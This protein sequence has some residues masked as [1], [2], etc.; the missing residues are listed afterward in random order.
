MDKCDYLTPDVH[1]MQQLDPVTAAALLARWIVPEPSLI[2]AVPAQRQLFKSG[3]CPPLLVADLLQDRFRSLYLSCRCS[4][5]SCTQSL[6]LRIL[7]H[8]PLDLSGSFRSTRDCTQQTR[9]NRPGKLNGCAYLDRGTC[10][11]RAVSSLM[12]PIAT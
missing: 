12:V 5:G 8:E 3:G 6:N 10:V 1:Y 7:G 4:G 2:E 9:G 11:F